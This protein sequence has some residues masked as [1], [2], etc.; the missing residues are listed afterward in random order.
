MT[1]A[2]IKWIE[3]KTLLG[4]DAHGKAM[5]MSSS[6]G[7]GVSPMQMLLLGLG[8]CT[9]IDV[10]SILQKQCQPFE[11][12]EIRSSQNPDNLPSFG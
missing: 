7:P 8:G 9:I 3:D 4:V 1:A 6:D 12:I 10:A 5:V 11:G 2:R